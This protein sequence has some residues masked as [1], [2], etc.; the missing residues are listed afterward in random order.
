MKHQ[1]TSWDGY[2][3]QIRDYTSTG[4]L[5]VLETPEG[6][7]L[8]KMV[9]PI[10]YLPNIKCPVLMINGSND[11]YW[12]VDALSLYWDELRMPK[13]VSIIPNA[14]HG[15]GDKHQAF[16]VLSAFAVSTTGAFKFP[17]V[18]MRLSTANGRHIASYAYTGVSM[19]RNRFLWTATSGDLKFHSSTWKVEDSLATGRA[20]GGMESGGMPV[21]DTK[22]AKAAFV[23][24]EY[25][26]AGHRFILTSPAK[27]VKKATD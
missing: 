13:A 27:V 20:S 5:E 18:D 14:G 7:K 11:P 4:L 21:A 16:D 17:M 8:E 25:E 24:V 3:E 10:A 19:K 12:T 23:A 9:D 1:F 2:S 22:R 6:Q 15:L 26:A